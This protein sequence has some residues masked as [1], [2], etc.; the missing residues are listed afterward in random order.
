MQRFRIGAITDEFSSDI[1]VAAG[2]MQELGMKGAELRVVGGKNIMDLSDAEIVKAMEILR[3]HGLEVV[4][5]ATPLLKCSLPDAPEIDS[6]FQQDIFN[7]K[8]SYED[9]PRLAERAF[10][11]A[12]LT[13]ANIIRVF[14]YWRVLTPEVVFERVVDALQEL[15]DKAASHGLIVGLENEHA[16]NIATAQ[17]TARVLA[18]ID[19]RNLQVVWDPANAYVSGEK[20]FPTGYQLLDSTRIAH[21]HAK[22]CTLDGHKPVWG[23]LGECDIDWQGQMDALAEDGYKGF[24]HLETHWAGPNGDKFEGSK[25]CGRN[26]KKLVESTA[27]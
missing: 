11:I 24:I 9:Q 26:L 23:P 2:A 16:C 12:K 6:R 7:A 21:V 8:H 22:D 15:S 20:P 3:K 14:S 19:H 25:I 10:R 13:G 1:A 17:E 27:L 18:A 4:A 5:I